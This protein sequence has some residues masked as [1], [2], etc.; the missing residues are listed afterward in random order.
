VEARQDIGAVADRAGQLPQ[1]RHAARLIV[2]IADVLPCQETLCRA[3]LASSSGSL[4]KYNSPASIFCLLVGDIPILHR[5][6]CGR[7]DAIS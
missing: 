1:Q 4:A 6:H 5:C 7:S 3:A 2:G